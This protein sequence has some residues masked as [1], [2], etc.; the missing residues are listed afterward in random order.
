[1]EVMHEICAGLDVHKDT[2]VACV[3]QIRGREV[4]RETRTFRTD[5]K[6]LIELFDWLAAEQVTHVVMESTGVYWKPV[7]RVLEGGFELVLANAAAVKNVPGRKSD[8]NDAQ[9]LADLIAHGLVRGSLVPDEKGQDLRDLTRTRKQLVREQV[10][11]RQR[12]QKVLERC[13]IKLASVVS[14]I[15]GTSGRAILDAIIAGERN[16]AKLA[17]LAS[18]QLKGKKWLPMAQSLRGAIRPHD[19]FMLGLHLRAIDAL[20][21]EIDAI[22][23]RL[24]EVLDESFQAAIRRLKTI[25][26]VSTRVAETIIAEI[27]TNMSVFKTSGHLVSWAGLCPRM[28]ESAGKRRDTRI[29]KGAPWLKTVLVQSAWAAIRKPGSY[30]R[31]RFLRLKAR[32]GPMKA[33]V[34]AAAKLLTAIYF[35]LRDKVDYRDLGA[36]HFEQLDRARATR[37]HVRQLEALGYSVEL[38]SAA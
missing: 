28:D 2:V 9:W 4:F 35:I 3:R 38:K 37:R 1:M 13:N 12:I 16:P 15:T 18:E 27:G 32:R 17:D 29:R 30:L 14:D 7:W 8:V 21:L 34:A 33:I 23:D 20:Q 25:P 36:S 11:H 6:S 24:T 19:V 31:A 10:Q 26:G 5:T 22:G